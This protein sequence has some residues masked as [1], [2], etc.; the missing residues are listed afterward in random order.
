MRTGIILSVFVSIVVGVFGCA[1]AQR[2]HLD[3]RAGADTSVGAFGMVIHGGAGTIRR[4]KMSP[5]R[6]A[7]YR[8]AL[9][10]ALG[11]GHEVLDAAGSS[12]DAVE[13]AIRILEDSP[14]FNAGKGAVFTSAGTN[15]MDASIMDGATLEAG[16][17]AA[18]KRIKNPITAA[19]M[20]ME[21]TPHVLLAGEGAETFAREVG[22]RLVSPEY[23]YTERRWA[24]L[25]RAKGAPATKSESDPGLEFRDPK[26]KNETGAGAKEETES[27]FGTVGA[28]ALDRNGN[29]AAATSTGGLTNKLFGRVGDSPIIGAGTYANNQTCGVS[30]TGRGEYFMRSLACYDVSAQMQYG[31]LPLGDAVRNVVHEKLPKLHGNGGRGGLIGLDARGNVAMEFNTEGMYRGYI[32]ESGK[33]TIKIFR[34]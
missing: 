8:A 11:A 20:V 26:R 22:I 4:D 3:A 13:A 21:K 29:L 25:Q 32:T 7:E 9:E 17:V 33:V 15:E 19:R 6:E 30:G 34:D 14:L 18:V 2:E 24:Q 5:Q 28:V 31:S 12:L 1:G 23:F 10:R 16:A 27:K